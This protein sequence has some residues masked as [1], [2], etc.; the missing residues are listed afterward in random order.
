[1]KK[2]FL[3][4]ILLVVFALPFIT[5]CKKKKSPQ[6]D[7]LIGA[8]AVTKV[9]NGST[10]VTSTYQG[11]YRIEFRADRTY[12]HTRRD[13]DGTFR[14]TT[15]TYSVAGTT[16]NLSGE[17]AANDKDQPLQNYSLSAD[18]KTLTY[19]Q[20]ENTRKQPNTLNFT[21]SKQ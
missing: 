11:N 5:S 16:I 17:I 9:M 19:T 3:L 13:L 18:G 10:D 8:W 14:N 21:L 20:L 7:P 15:G 2:N 4:L 1:M 12:S 6:P